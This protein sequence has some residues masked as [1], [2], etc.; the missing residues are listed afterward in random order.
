MI[1]VELPAAAGSN[2]W[3]F[4]ALVTEATT[5]G[6]MSQSKAEDAILHSMA[7]QT[8]A[9]IET[10]A[11]GNSRS[12]ATFAHKVSACIHSTDSD[13]AKHIS[14]MDHLTATSAIREAKTIASYDRLF[15]TVAV[16]TGYDSGA[17]NLA[18][19]VDNAESVLNDSAGGNANSWFKIVSADLAAASTS[20]A[21]AY[22]TAATN[23]S[24][25]RRNIFLHNYFIQ[26]N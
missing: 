13:G 20:L 9:V 16:E 21:T 5:N 6:G 4:G 3:Q 26:R 12:L 2:P 10:Q 7:K 15:L 11:S 22:E 8:Q 18:L 23:T 24:P 14:C 25:G 17:S 1:E 19:D